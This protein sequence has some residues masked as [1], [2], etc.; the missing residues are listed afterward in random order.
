[1]GRKLINKLVLSDHPQFAAG[2]SFNIVGIGTQSGNL[3]EQGGVG[4]L[5]ARQFMR[6]S[7]LL[8]LILNHP[9]N[10]LVAEQGEAEEQGDTQA[11]DDQILAGESI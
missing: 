10:P 7:L 1:M 8:P 2:N 5:E 11:G 3:L 9:Q 6:Q 4:F